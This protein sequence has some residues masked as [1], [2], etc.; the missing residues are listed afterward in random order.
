MNN[1]LDP[2]A[3][4]LA[5]GASLSDECCG[6]CRFVFLPPVGVPAPPFCRRHPPTPVI[7][8][9][10]WDAKNENVVS[11]TQVSVHPMVG[12]GNWCGAFERNPAE[13]N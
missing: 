1:L 13:V 6:K 7:V 8:R 3:N 11:N 10:N 2:A 5:P 12:L 9:A 4:V